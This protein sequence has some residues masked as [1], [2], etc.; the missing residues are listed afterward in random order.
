MSDDT[1]DGVEHGM[2]E[3]RRRM[4]TQDLRAEINTLRE[5]LLRVVQLTRENSELLRARIEALEQPD[6]SNE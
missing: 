6:K 4:L 5:Q 2:M 1:S 3:C